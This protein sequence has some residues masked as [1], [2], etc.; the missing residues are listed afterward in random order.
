MCDTVNT[1]S[2]LEGAAKAG[3]IFVS[4]NTYRLTRGAF[5]FQEMEP[6]QVKGKRD[7][8][9][10]YELLHAKVQPD[11]ARGVRARAELLVR[12]RLIG[13]LDAADRVG[14]LGRH[15]LALVREAEDVVRARRQLHL[16]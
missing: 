12:G 1:A 11:K 3:Q 4:R 13:R 6:V 7:S 10:V 14:Q 9:N 2:R 5:A 16:D 15:V 8:L